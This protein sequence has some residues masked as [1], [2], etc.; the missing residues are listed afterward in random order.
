[1]NTSPAATDEVPPDDLAGLSE[2]QRAAVTHRE[3]PLLV[4][5]GPGSGKTRVI[6]RRVAHLVRSGIAPGS[7]LAITFTNKAAREMRERIE[8]L[9]GV[10]TPWIST[11]HSFSARLLRRHI[12]RLEPYTTEFSI[13]DSD[14]TLAVIKEC[15]RQLDIATGEISPRMAQGEISRLKNQGIEDPEALPPGLEL[16]DQYVRKIYCLYQKVLEQSNA[17]DFDDLLLVAERLLKTQPDIL[18]RY[19]NQFRFILID[20]YQ[21]TNQVQYRIGR[22]LADGHKNLCVTGDPDQSIYSWRGADIGN[23]LSFERDFP[24]AKVVKLEQNYRSTRS[25]LE[26]ANVSI[27]HNENR[28][29]KTLWTENETGD[30]VRV[31]RFRSAEEEAHEIADLLSRLIESG[32]KASDVAIFYRINALSRELERALVLAGLPYVVI[33]SVEFYQRKEIKDLLAYLRLLANPRDGENLKR[34]INVP[35]RR[36]GKVT[37]EKLEARALREGVPLREVIHEAEHRGQAVRGAAL[38]N[39]TA[40][41]ETLSTLEERVPESGQLSIQELL[42]HVLDTTN[43]LDYLRDFDPENY[44]E[45]HENVSELLNATL[46]Y[47]QK[48]PDGGTL[49]GFLEEV[50]LLTGVDRWDAREE[51]IS[52]MTLHSAK[53]LEFPVVIIVGNE[54]GLLPLM[55]A[56]ADGQIDLDEERRLFYVGVT[57]AEKMLYLTHCQARNRFG[58][59]IP[60]RPS[61]FLDE[62]LEAEESGALELD[63]GTRQSLESLASAPWDEDPDPS[64]Q[65]EF[66]DVSGPS[67]FSL[68]EWDDE[69]ADEDPYPQGSRV[70]H[71]IYGPGE[72]VDSSGLGQRRRLT[73]VFESVGR[74]TIFVEHAK[75]RRLPG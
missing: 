18:E 34:I 59:E 54:D 70:S 13:Y 44:Q 73:I 3:G 39:V 36:L 41:S 32:R 5:A 37:V 15:I 65:A 38:K 10:V 4:I 42:Q 56:S 57:R 69:V 62:I 74:K 26:V 48:N 63:E 21:D 29:D 64:I 58:S 14:D 43:Y 52:L 72:I 67:R 20:E 17:L 25:I 55:R 6:T 12:Y 61:D 66:P 53:G 51:R 27:R 35:S 22:L 49:T 2:V 47:D 50:A 9:L 45:R 71:D 19:R 46:A 40:F 11:F 75:L 24:G 60:A 23:I 1:M 30:P 68:D 8:E 16:F 31:Y 28:P 33:G 7:I